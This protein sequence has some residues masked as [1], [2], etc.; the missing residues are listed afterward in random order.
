MDLDAVFGFEPLKM[1][2]LVNP[3][4]QQALSYITER[5]QGPLRLSVV[6]SQ[7]GVHPSHLCRLFK[8]ELR[9]SFRRCILMMRLHRSRQL[10]AESDKSIKQI[11]FEIGFGCPEAFSRAFKQQVGYPPGQYRKRYRQR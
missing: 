5:Y 1:G 3:K 9:I 8:K 10:L 4:V 11:S 7:I 2:P 6:A